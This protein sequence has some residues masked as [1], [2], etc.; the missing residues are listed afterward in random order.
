MVSLSHTTI[1]VSLTAL[2]RTLQQWTEANP[3]TEERS[4]AKYLM[5]RAKIGGLQYERECKG[6]TLSGTEDG[7]K[8]MTNSLVVMQETSIEALDNWDFHKWIYEY[9][10]GQHNHVMAIWKL[11]S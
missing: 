7:A 1:M 5:E 11:V 3:F 10:R 4:N 6:L 2:P 9:D 8:Y